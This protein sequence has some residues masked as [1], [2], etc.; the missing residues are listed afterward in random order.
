MRV[1][2]AVAV[3]LVLC[4]ALAAGGG[5][6]DSGRASPT[7]KRNAMI[8]LHDSLAKFASSLRNFERKG[9]QVLTAAV[10]EEGGGGVLPQAAENG[11]HAM[12]A[13]SGRFRRRRHR[14]RGLGEDGA[15]YAESGG[16]FKP[17]SY[18]TPSADELVQKRD[19]ESFRVIR[20]KILHHGREKEEDH[21]AGVARRLPPKTTPCP[22]AHLVT[23]SRRRAT[24][25]TA[26]TA[27]MAKAGKKSSTASST[28][29]S[30]A[31]CAHD[32]AAKE[33][34]E[35]TQD[36]ND[37][38]RAH[39]DEEPHGHDASE[40]VSSSIDESHSDGD[41]V[42]N[43]EYDGPPGAVYAGSETTTKVGK[44]TGASP[45]P[46]K[47]LSRGDHLRIHIVHRPANAQAD[48]NETF[49]ANHTFVNKTGHDVLMVKTDDHF[50]ATNGSKVFKVRE[51][52]RN[53][54]PAGVSFNNAETLRSEEQQ[55]Y[56][57]N[58]DYMEEFEKRVRQ[59][60]ESLQRIRNYRQPP[61]A[62]IRTRREN[63]RSM[64]SLRFAP[65]AE[66]ADTPSRRAESQ[67]SRVIGA[68]S[69]NIRITI[70]RRVSKDEGAQE[71]VAA[72]PAPIRAEVNPAG[73]KLRHNIRV[74]GPSS[75]ELPLKGMAKRDINDTNVV[76]NEQADDMVNVVVNNSKS[77]APLVDT[78]DQMA[79]PVSYVDGSGP[80]LSKFEQYRFRAIALT[81]V[82]A[83][84][85]FF[86][87]SVVF[88][89]V[90]FD[91][92]NFFTF[93]RTFKYSALDMSSPLDDDRQ[94]AIP[95]SP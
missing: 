48:V 81:S 14:G 80:A 83:F 37:G 73:V 42:T 66:R 34:P 60:N 94:D 26:R 7:K 41:D 43:T 95:P 27:K 8:D 54:F 21:N 87:A 75:R 33:V 86:T 47:L 9:Q 69:G 67:N 16:P 45:K 92:N 5:V 55:P 85:S 44:W 59:V 58:Q 70:N 30:V 72:K 63:V 13:G 90:Y 76:E 36:H 29:A 71:T 65:A 6:D 24:T 89:M 35:E 77:N 2:T 15:Y 51:A 53:L 25:T 17:I 93:K 68:S 91:L 4:C 88:T 62:K 11:M 49:F 31:Y 74:L 61:K 1:R 12:S 10:A 50:F 23:A 64:R 18:A 20:I 40:Q 38:E 52:D 19:D 78:F 57:V 56:L 46:Y 32:D 79:T 28:S 3:V 39:N 82:V 84:A 22:V